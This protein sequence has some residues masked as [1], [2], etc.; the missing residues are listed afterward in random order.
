MRWP[1]TRAMMSFG[2]PAGNGTI[3][4]IDLLGKSSAAAMT[5]D[6]STDNAVTSV[7]RTFTRASSHYFPSW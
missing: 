5:G 1:T 4:R 3:S 7:R 6:S 2:P